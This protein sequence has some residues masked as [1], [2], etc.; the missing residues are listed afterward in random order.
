MA[1]VGPQGHRKRLRSFYETGKYD[2]IADHNLLELFLTCVI[3]RRDVKPLA[4]DLIN[5][6]G[7]LEGVCSAPPD[8]LVS[9]KGIGDK[10]ALALSLIGT[11][12]DRIIDNSQKFSKKITSLDD[13]KEYSKLVL[14]SESVEKMILVRCANDGEIL[15]TVPLAVGTANAI[16][17]GMDAIVKNALLGNGASFFIAHNHPNG[18]CMASQ[19][20]VD[21]TIALKS[22]FDKMHTDFIDHIIVSPEGC[23]AILNESIPQG[24]ICL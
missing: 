5:T 8:E 14:S 4:Y 13:V 18:S 17:I 22:V 24:N 3:P 12:N 10:T 2:N 15:A 7:S 1:T 23:A 20:D 21:F 11:I 6:F 19:N 9:V 16:D